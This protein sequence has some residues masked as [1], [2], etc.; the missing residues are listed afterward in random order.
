MTNPQP[1]PTNIADRK[2]QA[3]AD[4]ALEQMFGYFTREE[5]APAQTDANLR[6][7]A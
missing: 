2:A 6:R 5:V 3:A 4:A 7:A 1:T